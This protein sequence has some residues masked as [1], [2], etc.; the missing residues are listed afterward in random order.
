VH[1]INTFFVIYTLRLDTH[2]KKNILPIFFQALSMRSKLVSKIK[3]EMLSLTCNS[4]WLLSRL[5]H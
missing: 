2:T 4:Q 1:D 5:L 3:K